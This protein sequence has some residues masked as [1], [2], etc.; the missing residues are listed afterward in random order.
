M[1]GEGDLVASIADMA[2]METLGTEAVEPHFLGDG[3]PS[4]AG[5]EV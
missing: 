3:A 2:V 4:L 5:C 1:N